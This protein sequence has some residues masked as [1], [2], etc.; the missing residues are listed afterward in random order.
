MKIKVQSGAPAAA[1]VSPAALTFTS[2]NW[3]TTQTVTVTGVDDNVDQSGNRSITITHDRIIDRYSYKHNYRNVT[4]PNVMAMVVDDDTGGQTVINICDRTAQIEKAI[5]NTLGKTQADCGSITPAELAGIDDL[6]IRSIATLKDGDLDNLT[7][8]ESLSLSLTGLWR[9]SS[10]EQDL[11]CSLSGGK[12][13]QRDWASG[14]FFRPKIIR[15]LPHPT[16]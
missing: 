11:P 9:I 16:F 10:A 3:N 13:V 6:N 14:E 15:P 4:I 8:L 5:L 2:S 12:T 7:G 1:T